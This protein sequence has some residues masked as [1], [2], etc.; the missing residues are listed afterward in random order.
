MQ[1]IVN[2]CMVLCSHGQ[3][4]HV[5]QVRERIMASKDRGYLIEPRVFHNVLE[6]VEQ[7]IC[8]PR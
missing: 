4:I 6:I 2:E 1:A 7:N 5:G 8:P 3:E